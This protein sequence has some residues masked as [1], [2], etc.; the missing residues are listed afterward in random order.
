MQQQIMM[1]I[2]QRLKE[3]KKRMEQKV[4]SYYFNIKKCKNIKKSNFIG[5]RNGGFY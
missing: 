1:D 5:R 2:R 3:L 4:V